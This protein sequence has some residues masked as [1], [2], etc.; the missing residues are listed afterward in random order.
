ME[1]KEEGCLPF[2]EVLIIRS[3]NRLDFVI[4]RKETRTSLLI[5]TSMYITKWQDSIFQ[6]IG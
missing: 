6:H 2:L 1:L 5:Y 3:Q 4:Y